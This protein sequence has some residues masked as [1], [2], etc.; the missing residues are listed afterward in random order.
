MSQ[1]RENLQTDG[2]TDGQTLFYRT[3][4]AEAGGPEKNYDMREPLSLKKRRL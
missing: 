4:P 2:R 1:F 3:L